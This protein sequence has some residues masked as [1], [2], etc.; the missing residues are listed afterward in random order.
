MS[1][2]IIPRS[3]C[4][5]K[6]TVH[7]SRRPASYFMKCIINIIIMIIILTVQRS[8]VSRKF[9]FEIRMRLVTHNLVY[10]YNATTPMTFR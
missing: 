10:L 1:D 5:W 8:A 3:N 7:V 6:E 4:I 2:N 9:V